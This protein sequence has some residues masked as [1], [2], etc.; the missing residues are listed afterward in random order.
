MKIKNETP[1]IYHLKRNNLHI[2]K[3]IKDYYSST[4]IQRNWLTYIFKKKYIPPKNYKL[5]KKLLLNIEYLPPSL[6]NT[7]KGGI[8]YKNLLSNYSTIS[9]TSHSSN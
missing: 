7:F 3:L 6:C 2:C 1:Y 4:L 5:K 8:K 9:S